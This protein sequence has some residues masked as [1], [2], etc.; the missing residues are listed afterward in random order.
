[1]NGLG[2]RRHAD[3]VGAAIVTHH[4]AGGVRAVAVTI[5]RVARIRICSIPPVVIM[6]P[7]GAGG[8]VYAAAVVPG[9]RGVGLIQAG[10][11]AGHHRARAIHA[12]RPYIIR[13]DE[14]EVRLHRGRPFWPSR[15]H[16]RHIQLELVIG[17]DLGHIRQ[18]CDGHQQLAIAA[19]HQD[20]VDNIE[21]LV[22][23]A[24]AV[25]VCPQRALRAIGGCHQGIENELAFLFLGLEIV[26][27][28][29]VSLLGHPDEE[30]GL[31]SRINF[32]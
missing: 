12:H 16:V 31:A 3:L 4:R 17:R 10:I 13:V 19:A 20:L 32:F 7:G 2:A 14:S 27:R 9:N 23:H 6:V 1:M 22:V 25:Q 11:I 29:Q 26:G 5:I 8:W 18:R 21:C 24:L 15:A 28:A 30:I